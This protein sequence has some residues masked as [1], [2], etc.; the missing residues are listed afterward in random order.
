MQFSFDENGN[1]ILPEPKSV[2]EINDYIKSLI[3]E[4]MLLQDIYVKGE[5]SN[6]KK[7][8][9]SGHFYFTLK[10]EKSEIRA[11]MFRAYSQRVRFKIENGM[12]VVVHARVGVYQQ[13]GSYQLYVD[14]IIPDG[15]GEL[16]LAYEQLKAKLA[17]EGLFE[18]ENKKPLPRFPKRIG[19]ITSATGAAV[20]DIINVSIRRYPLA[21]L[22]LFPA[23]VQGEG[24]SSELIRA[25]E[26]F[27]IEK[28]VDVI[29]IG[30]GGGSIEDLWSFND[31]MLARTIFMSKIPVIS[32]V[33]HE[34]DFTICDF[35]ADKRAPTPSAAAELATPDINE[36]KST[37]NSFA[38]RAINAFSNT[39]NMYKDIL[40]GIE[41]S[42]VFKKPLSML[43]TPRMHLD[44]LSDKISFSFEKNLSDKK[45]KFSNINGRLVALNPMAILSRGYGA[46][47]NS[48][49][50][51]VNSIDKINIDDKIKIN[52]SDGSINAV[53]MSKERGK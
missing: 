41:D 47:F 51:I 4:E 35:V 3:E 42:K 14:T 44:A 2:S 13:G 24:S 40:S 43:D 8:I 19:I 49:N 16:H 6:F 29:I 32:A 27:N 20:R 53:V 1:E 23:L 26:Y 22:V 33:G 28:C 31:E 50:E 34:T 52:L 17:G 12:K 30:R 39:I 7:H 37:L 46:L 11:I 18:E 10:D 48:N 15:I 36:L 45:N 9:S 5:I 38:Q 25:L 21:E